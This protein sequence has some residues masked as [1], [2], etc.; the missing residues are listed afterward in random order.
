MCPML[1]FA[2]V[3]STSQIAGASWKSDKSIGELRTERRDG[4][5]I[6]AGD[7]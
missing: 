1:T 5:R 2:L 4:L 3:Y 7:Y 6:A